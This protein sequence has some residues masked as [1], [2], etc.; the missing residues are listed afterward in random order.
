VP[1]T[2]EDITEI[3]RAGRRCEVC[4][5]GRHWRRF[6]IVR[7]ADR[8]AVV[9]CP[10]CHARFA[11]DPPVGRLAEGK[12]KPTSAAARA[13]KPAKPAK[14][15]QARPAP[16]AKGPA[17]PGPDRLLAAIKEMTGAF[18]T[19]TAARAAGLNSER[20]QVRLEE[21]EARGE[22]QRV[23]NRW[24]AEAPPSELAS[25]MD[26]LQARTSNLRIVRDKARVS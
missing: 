10:S 22:V 17:E 5:T 7:P 26:R 14:P 16:E 21:L 13:S 9:L 15:Q 1:L 25:A 6:E 24:S 19:A 23:G 3:E 4:H 12:A 8:V 2:S 11:D 18:S 20:T